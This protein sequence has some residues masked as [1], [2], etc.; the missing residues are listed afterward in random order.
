L[1]AVI[2]VLII[3]LA[4]RIREFPGCFRFAKRTDAF[5]DTSATDM[6]LARLAKH[7]INQRDMACDR[8]GIFWPLREK[9]QR[10]IQPSSDSGMGINANTIRDLTRSITKEETIRVCSCDFMDRFFQAPGRTP[11]IRGNE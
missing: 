10:V 11:L 1:S 8:R 6:P 5:G 7:V 4:I 2:I 9:S 3:H